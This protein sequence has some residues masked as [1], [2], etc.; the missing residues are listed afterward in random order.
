[1][2][3][4]DD[5]SIYGLDSPGTNSAGF[6]S[7]SGYTAYDMF[8]L[9]AYAGQTVDL[10][11]VFGSDG[12]IHSYN[13]WYIYS[14]ELGNIGSGGPAL[15]EDFN[16]FWSTTSPPAGWTILDFGS[17]GDTFGNNND[18]YR[19]YFS[20][21]SSYS[22]RV[23][24]YPNENQDEWLISP[25]VPTTGTSLFLQFDHYFNQGWFAGWS[26][27]Y[28]YLSV[29]SGP[30]QTVATYVG[31]DSRG[32]MSY[33]ISYAAGQNVQVA[34]RYTG[35]NDWYWY[36][37]NVFIGS[38][39]V[40]NVVEDLTDDIKDPRPA[41]T[42]NVVG[43]MKG[44]DLAFYRHTQNAMRELVSLELNLE[45]GMFHDDGSQDSALD[46]YRACDT[47]T[48]YDIASAANE[49]GESYGYWS[50]TGGYGYFF[51]PGKNGNGKAGLTGS[52]AVD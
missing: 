6:T 8:D 40:F 11:F 33:D 5:S 10:R 4:Y 22:A 37:D 42:V 17:S 27:G 24:W 29:N 9:T 52:E 13:G 45:N 1:M 2:G 43:K 25:V 39:P 23:A 50:H 47:Q 30:W 32:F 16:S 41:G 19:S 46:A 31:V 15:F 7:Y 36:V 12:S 35:N 28:L 14:V 20:D 18:W 3:G 44:G 26:V 48:A 38:P 49:H 51:T 21:T 34:F